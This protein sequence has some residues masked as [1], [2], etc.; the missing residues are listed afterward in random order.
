MPA[1]SEFEIIDA[2]Q[3]FSLSLIASKILTKTSAYYKFLSTGPT[4]PHLFLYLQESSAPLFFEELNTLKKNHLILEQNEIITPNF[5]NIQN[6]LIF[7]L[8]DMDCSE[9]V[10]NKRLERFSELIKYFSTDKQHEFNT[11]SVH[12]QHAWTIESKSGFKSKLHLPPTT[13]DLPQRKL[14]FIHSQFVFETSFISKTDQFK[15]EGLYEAIYLTLKNILG[16]E[17]IE[18]YSCEE[19]NRCFE[20]IRGYFSRNFDSIILEYLFGTAFPKIKVKTT[21]EQT[22]NSIGF[23]LKLILK[24]EQSELPIYGKI[25][26]IDEKNSL[27]FFVWSMEPE[28]L[29]R[30]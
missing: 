25:S 24:V 15:V 21:T 17:I 27:I 29:Q 12:F 23:D 14:R 6:F 30:V 16:L 20:E 8:N 2:L 4:V 3:L 18:F 10:K 1:L 11:Q 5:K 19:K 28:Y 9:S 22:N 7:H 13:A 26:N